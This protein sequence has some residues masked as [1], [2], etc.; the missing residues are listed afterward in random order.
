MPHAQGLLPSEYPNGLPV[1]TARQHPSA[2]GARTR[3]YPA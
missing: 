1:D 3:T 2:F